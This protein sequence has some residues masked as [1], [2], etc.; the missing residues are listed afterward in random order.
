M[1]AV[2]AKQPPKEVVKLSWAV[3]AAK[4]KREITFPFIVRW[5]HL[6]LWEVPLVN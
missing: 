6:S 4:A 2:G 1:P 5:T 3:L